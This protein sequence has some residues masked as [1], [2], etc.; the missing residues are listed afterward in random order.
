M[1]IINLH[2][3]RRFP[4]RPISA[5]VLSQRACAPGKASL[6]V[7]SSRNNTINGLHLANDG[8]MSRLELNKPTEPPAD[9]PTN[10]TLDS[11]HAA[12]TEMDATTRLI[13]CILV[14]L[15]VQPCWPAATHA[16]WG[17]SSGGPDGLS[18]IPLTMTLKGIGGA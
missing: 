8:E 5:S 7:L 13:A 18:G 15:A 2:L 6:C 17:R 12:H 10:C 4:D 14:H 9:R 16:T 3:F 1:D 11:T